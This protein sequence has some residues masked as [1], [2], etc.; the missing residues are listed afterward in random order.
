MGFRFNRRIRILPGV[1]L[2]IG[3]TGISTSVGK[4][5]ASLTVG[6]RG[7]RATI[8]APGTGLSYSAVSKKPTASSSSKSGAPV[9]VYVIAVLAVL[10]FIGFLVG[11]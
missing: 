6:K 2:N 7:T 3:K 10:W 4:R 5:G 11:N 9:W 1:H 8:G